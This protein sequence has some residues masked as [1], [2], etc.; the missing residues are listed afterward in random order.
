[1]LDDGVNRY[2]Q[3][4]YE[5]LVKGR[6]ATRRERSDG[7]IGGHNY[8]EFK[9][10]LSLNGF[11]P[12]DCIERVVPSEEFPGL[13]NI[14]YRIPKRMGNQIVPGEYRIVSNPKTVYDPAYY[15]NMQMA[16]WG[17]EAMREAKQ[18]GR[19]FGLKYIGRASNGMW[20]VG[21]MDPATGE[22]SNYF[23]TLN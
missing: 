21:F 9:E 15:S 19:K 2:K 7:I 22:I 10:T 13:C 1:M 20:F 16:E 14:Y 11:D 3:G 18:A 23:P 17:Q 12:A 4:Y 5:H 8:E 6:L